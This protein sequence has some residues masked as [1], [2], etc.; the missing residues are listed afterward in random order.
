ML[1]SW[2]INSVNHVNDADHQNSQI[3]AQ[4]A[5]SSAECDEQKSE[6]REQ[7]S[8]RANQR[9]DQRTEQRAIGVQAARAAKVPPRKP[10]TYDT[11]KNHFSA[12]TVWETMNVFENSEVLSKFWC[13]D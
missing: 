3:T 11:S 2:A 7:Q 9:A 12:S 6:S 1:L 8:S 4:R 5:E 10:V 13:C